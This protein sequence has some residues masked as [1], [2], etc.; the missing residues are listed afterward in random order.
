MALYVAIAL[1]ATLA[2]VD[3]DHLTRRGTLLLIWGTTL[4]LAVAHYVAFRLAST[5][6]KGSHLGRDDITT[7]GVQFLGAITV[8]AVCTLT[9][10]LL[11]DDGTAV[12][13]AEFTLAGILGVTG[14][15]AGRGNGASRGRSALLGGGVLLAGLATAAAKYALTGH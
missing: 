10:L 15:L 6:A 11:A 2:A 14:Y 13:V 12:D 9:G 3:P 8:P 1:L 7:A 5:L 4:G